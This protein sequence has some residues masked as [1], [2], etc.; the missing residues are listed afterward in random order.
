MR[1]DDGNLRGSAGVAS[2]NGGAGEFAEG[3]EEFF[4]FVRDVGCALVAH[5]GIL[6]GGAAEDGV[7]PRVA[8]GD[9]GRGAGGLVRHFT[10]EELVKNDA[11]GVEVGRDANVFGA[12]EDFGSGVAGGAE[13][14]GAFVVGI[15][16]GGEAEVTDL[17][18]G[19]GIE[20]DVGGLD[21]AVN[22]VGGVGVGKSAADA[23]DEFAGGGLVDGLAVAGVVEGLAVDQLHDDVGHAIGLSKVVDANEVGVVELGHGAGLGLELFAESWVVEFAGQE[24]DGDGPI[25]GNLVGTIDGAHP[26]G[27]DEVGDFVAAEQL[28]QF[29]GFWRVKFNWVAH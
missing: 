14:G 10:G 29:F 15:R 21:V 11:D 17:G 22:D 16:G 9:G 4:E 24:L 5:G 6:A 13:D 28:T 2:A 12:G 27:G 1:G 25:E 26:A 19:V 7:E 8:V 18:I 23:D 20:E 3:G